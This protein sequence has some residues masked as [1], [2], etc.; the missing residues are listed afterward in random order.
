MY[1]NQKRTVSTR[2]CEWLKAHFLYRIGTSYSVQNHDLNL[3]H[4]RRANGLPSVVRLNDNVVIHI[5]CTYVL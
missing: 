2:M 3:L 1:E 5:Q 4:I